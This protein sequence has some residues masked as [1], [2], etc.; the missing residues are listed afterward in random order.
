MSRL[1]A[2][3]S[4]E[5]NKARYT[6]VIIVHSGNEIPILLDRSIYKILKR[7]NYIWYINDKD[8]VY[9]IRRYKGRSGAIYE[10]YVY[11]HDMV[12]RI[13]RSGYS[14]KDPSKEELVRMMHVAIEPEDREYPIV[15]IDNVHFD[16]RYSNLQ[17]DTPD[18]NHVKNTKKK[19][20]T[21][22]LK[23]HGI[24]VQELPTY[25]WYMKADKTHGDRFCIEIPDEISWRSTSSTRVSLRYKLEEVKKYLRFLKTNRPDIFDYFCMNGDMSL[26]GK[27]LLREYNKMIRHV[28][29]T[30][31]IPEKSN[32]DV[33]IQKD[34][35][36]LTNEE[37]YLLCA[38]DPNVGTL[39]I[40][41]A[42]RDYKR[43][44]DI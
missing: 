21:I 20:R 37:I 36:D 29:F 13:G 40:G 14:Q 25:V 10:E 38:F 42:M 30:I 6:V 19:K 33:F 35:S 11:M 22:N 16:N 9:T 27:I 4:L 23:R 41:G 31:P 18:K 5:Y 3:V 15:H 7:M 17:Y 44:M 39:D 34:T 1:G 24:S 28:G 43:V 12:M 26:Q 2:K 8:H 32:T